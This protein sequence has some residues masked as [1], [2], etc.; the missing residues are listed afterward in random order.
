MTLK[1]SKLGRS[2]TNA[3]LPENRAGY[4]PLREEEKVEKER[5]VGTNILV[6]GRKEH[7]DLK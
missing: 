3:L 7:Q 5:V 1:T 4:Q 6:S 2:I